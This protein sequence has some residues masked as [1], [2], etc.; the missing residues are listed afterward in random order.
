MVLKSKVAVS[1]SRVDV[2]VTSKLLGCHDTGLLDHIGNKA[3]T[4]AMGGDLLVNAC[5]LAISLQDLVEL[6]PTGIELAILSRE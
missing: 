2:G 6:P 4:E 5:F 3:V 1:L